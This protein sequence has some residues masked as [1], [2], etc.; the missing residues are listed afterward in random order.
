[1][2]NTA[3]RSTKFS[4][5]LEGPTELLKS[6]GFVFQNDLNGA[7]Q[8]V[9]HIRGT[10]SEQFDYLKAG[11]PKSGWSEAGTLIGHVAEYA[12][13]NKTLGWLAHSAEAPVISVSRG[14]T[15]SGI[16]GATIGVLQPVTDEKANFGYAKFSQAAVGYGTFATMSG[17]EK[18]LAHGSF[19]GRPGRRSVADSISVNAIAGAISGVVGSEIS[20]VLNERRL[21]SSAELRGQAGSG[22]VFGAV[23]GAV[24][25]KLS[26]V[27]LKDDT[28]PEFKKNFP[29]HSLPSTETFV[30]DH[31]DADKPLES[32]IL[33]WLAQNR[34][35]LRPENYDSLSQGLGK[36]QFLD[37]A[38]W[39]PEGRVKIVKALRELS[40]SDLTKD[41]QMDEFIGALKKRETANLNSLMDDRDAAA[42]SRIEWHNAFNELSEAQ[43]IHAPDSSLEDI[44]A[45]D[46]SKIRHPEIQTALNKT[47]QA[48]NAYDMGPRF[49]AEDAQ[50]YFADASTSLKS[51]LKERK[52]PDLQY[53]SLPQGDS[54]AMAY[55]LDRLFVSPQELHRELSGEQISAEFHEVRHH[56]DGTFRSDTMPAYLKRVLEGYKSQASERNATQEAAEV[57]RSML[58]WL[59]SDKTTSKELLKGLANPNDFQSHIWSER[60]NNDAGIMMVKVGDAGKTVTFAKKIP[61]EVKDL[62]RQSQLSNSADSELAP[63][64]RERLKQILL[65]REAELD[66]QEQSLY[67]D[68]YVGEKAEQRAWSAGLL[69]QLRTRAWGI[70]HSASPPDLPA[71]KG[72]ERPQDL[73]AFG[74]VYDNNGP[75]F[76]E[77]MIAKIRAVEDKHSDWPW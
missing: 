31:Y 58:G 36:N 13:L 75:A 10:K 2:D 19:F 22:A 7:Q 65:K 76:S 63:E 37:F 6:A 55:A 9:D 21:S 44:V 72:E 59:D 51:F 33:S 60:F 61:Q 35:E 17:T 20:S 14:A 73:G 34:P 57:V 28:S 45:G 3:D 69:M 24:D 53:T 40:E 68:G 49:K 64:L 39:S 56:E 62:Y 25:A 67:L 71:I 42:K 27:K 66:A 8:I 50:Q 43:R 29:D 11:D 1:M 77:E 46:A 52:L 74:Y 5:I 48:E 4:K 26:R 16:S 41:G 30:K 47:L 32:P 18:F 12:V 70:P 23:F 38:A 15:I 54:N